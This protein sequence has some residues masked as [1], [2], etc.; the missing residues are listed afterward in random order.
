M[1]FYDDMQAVATDVLGTFKQG[2]VEYQP[3][4]RTGGTVDE[5]GAIVSTAKIV[6]KAAVRGVMFKYVAGN[7]ALASDLQVTS[8]VI[9]GGFDMKGFIFVDDVQYKIVSIIP[10]PAAGTTVAVVLIIRK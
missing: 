3:I 10:K 8:A 1:G 9:A 4:S 2:K 5:P 6:L 7:L